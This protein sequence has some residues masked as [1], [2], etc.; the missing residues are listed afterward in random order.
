[1]NFFENA[2]SGPTGPLSL[3]KLRQT[4]IRLEDTIVF[5]LIE[6]AQFAHNAII[7]EPGK[8]DFKDFGGSFMEWVLRETEVVHAKVR[9]FASPDENPFFD[10]LPDAILPALEYPPVLHPN[11]INVNPD[12]LRMYTQEIIPAI[13]RP[14]DDL[15]YGSA[16]TRDV[17]CLQALSRRIHCGKFVAE[18]KFLDPAQHDLYVDAIRRGDAARCEELLT[19]KAVE[20]QVVRRMRRKA[21]I[22]GQDITIDGEVETKPRPES[23][24]GGQ[25]SRKID[26]DVVVNMYEK[27]VI[28]LTVKVEVDYLMRRLT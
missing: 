22:Y 9:R 24:T 5:A 14:G 15:Q 13:C 12:I 2:G 21:L 8:F 25:G 27:F 23:P 28:P 4:L 6:R 20:A 19:N 1:M 11:N 10:D 16:S 18:A 7:Y 3:G 26:L 17:E